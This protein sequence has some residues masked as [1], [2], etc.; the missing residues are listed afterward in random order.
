MQKNYIA[1]ITA[2][3]ESRRIGG[4]KKELI[5]ID[6]KAVIYH[7]VLP[8]VKTGLFKTILITCQQEYENEFR[9]CLGEIS[10]YNVIE[11][12][13]GGKTRQESVLSGLMAM[14]HLDPE[15]VLIHDGARPFITEDIIKNVICETLKHGACAPLIPVIDS[16]K[17]VENNFIKEHPQRQSLMAIQTPQGFKFSDILECHIKAKD[18]KKHF[19][20]DTEIYS[21][22]GKNIYIV[23]G[24]RE[25]L[26]ITYLDD[27]KYFTK[28]RDEI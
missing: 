21:L 5:K 7:T 20:D 17:T 4:T 23:E 9:N 10:K 16:I 8:F 12:A 27:I 18:I 22:S 25:N 6:E 26:K 3:G 2:A 11:F 19:T 13:P 14:K 1:L 24:S 28:G 15:I